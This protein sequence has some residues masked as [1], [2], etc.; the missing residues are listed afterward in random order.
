MAAEASPCCNGNISSIS[1]IFV[2]LVFLFCVGATVLS[3]Y[4]TCVQQHESVVLVG[5]VRGG[6]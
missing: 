6:K 3:N 4:G 1:N 2:Q 5:G